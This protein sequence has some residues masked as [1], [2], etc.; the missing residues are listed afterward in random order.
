MTQI[1]VN[2]RRSGLC[3]ALYRTLYGLML[4][5]S[6]YVLAAEE[7][8]ARF[9]PQPAKV[10]VAI[11]S[12]APG[13]AGGTGHYHVEIAR[14]DPRLTPELSRIS[15]WLRRQSWDFSED[16]LRTVRRLRGGVRMD[17]PLDDASRLYLNFIPGN[18]E[19]RDGLR[20]QPLSEEAA[21]SGSGPRWS[22]G[23]LLH[24]RG[25]VEG[26][27]MSEED[28]AEL[29]LTPQL[30]VNLDPRG[31]TLAGSRQL[32]FQHGDWVHPGNGVVLAGNA[33]QLTLRWKF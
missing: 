22:V 24:T 12:L 27:E 26:R 7:P 19:R 25:R 6:Q 14:D 29:G 8:R 4:S 30:S 2:R 21:G 31:S 20:W 17:V 9:A 13:R 28:K 10:S 32:T 15:A 23:C 18:R 1:A 3:A 33:W 11:E 16:D 5:Y